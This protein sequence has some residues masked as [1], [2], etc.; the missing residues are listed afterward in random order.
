MVPGYSETAFRGGCVLALPGTLGCG[1]GIPGTH[2]P[3]KFTTCTCDTDLC[4]AS[5]M[6]GLS[7]SLKI[8]FLVSLVKL[9]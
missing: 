6:I 4:N 2:D 5:A 9:I 1:H 3:S 8:V 7:S